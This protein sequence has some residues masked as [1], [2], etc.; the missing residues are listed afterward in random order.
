MNRRLAMLM[1]LLLGGWL[2]LDNAVMAKTAVDALPSYPEISNFKYKRSY[3]QS[4]KSRDLDFRAPPAH[5]SNPNQRYLVYVDRANSLRLQKVR[6]LEPNAFVRQYQGKSVIQVGVFNREA[7]AKQ[8]VRELKARGIS[9]QIVSLS[10]KQATELG[11][12]KSSKFYFVVIPSSRRELPLLDEKVKRLR[13]DA[14]DN[15]V[16][17]SQR[18]QPMGPHVRVGPFLEREQAER[19]NRYLRKMGVS[20]GRVYYGF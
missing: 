13:A 5:Q 14:R 2:G 9:S 18:E 20:H 6:Q 7:D 8:R 17:V 3:L 11:Q 4:F 1:T 15:T 12:K 10:S 16:V 19:W